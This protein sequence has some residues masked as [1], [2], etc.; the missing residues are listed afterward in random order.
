MI[1]FGLFIEDVQMYVL[2]NPE[3]DLTDMIKQIVQID[4]K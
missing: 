4:F 2:R 1:L 3:L